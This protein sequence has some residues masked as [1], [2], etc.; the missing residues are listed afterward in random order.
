MWSSSLGK[1]HQIF[2]DNISK[3]NILNN[4]FSSVFTTDNDCSSILDGH[5]YSDIPAIQIDTQGIINLLH[6]LDPHKA[7][8]PDGIPARFLKEM[9]NSIAPALVPMYK[10]SLK[11]I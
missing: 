8:G 9:C 4:Q 2:S 1:N 3:T 11:V 6:N 10:A 7:P 5:P